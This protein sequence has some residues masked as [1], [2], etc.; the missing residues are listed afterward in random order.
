MRMSCKCSQRCRNQ[1]NNHNICRAGQE[2]AAAE[3]PLAEWEHKLSRR[4]CV[5]ST[6]LRI[7]CLMSESRGASNV[8]FMAIL[9]S[10]LVHDA[11]GVISPAPHPNTHQHTHS[12]SGADT[13]H[14]NDNCCEK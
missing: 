1:T 2:Q 12:V 14:A 5:A 3:Y 7:V 13:A 10:L 9:C 6:R 8:I 4:M 11:T